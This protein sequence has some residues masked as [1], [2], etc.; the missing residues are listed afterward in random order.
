MSIR[1]F[2]IIAHIDHGKSTLA[3]RL[4]ERTGL[5]VGEKMREQMMD[6]MEL[7]RERGITIKAKTV[8]LTYE[9]KDGQTYILN[10]ID[11]PGHVD[12]TYEVSRALAAC[13][14]ALL[15]VDASQGVEAQTLA[16]F[17]L[18]KRQNLRI[19]SV[20]NKIDLPQSD[21][22]EIRRQIL[23]ILQIE[24][25]PLF[26]SAK[27][28]VGIEEILEAIV[29]KIPAPAGEAT[30]PLR[31]LVFD[32]LFSTFRGVIIT[33]RLFEGR[34]ARGM[35]VRF[36]SSP[37][38]EFEV[39]ELGYLILGMKPVRELAA[40]EVGYVILG[41]KDLSL[42]KMGDT[43]TESSRPATER[44]PGFQEL[45]PFVFCG[46][47][48]VASSDFTLLTNSLEKLHLEDSSFFFQPETSAALGFGF[49]CGFL[50]L[51]HMDIIKERIQREFNLP[52][53]ITA[54]NVV[55]KVK[56]KKSTSLYDNP[57]QFPPHGEIEKIEE[58][59]IQ[60]T[61]LT[62]SAYV[63]AV[64]QLCEA[65]R[66]KYISLRYITPQRAVL[67]YEMPLA[68]AILDFYDGLKSVSRG[69]GSLDY[70]PIGYR[71]G[72]LAKLE[73]LLA[74]E[75]VDA[76]SSIT[77]RER[78]YDQGR[79]LALKLKE[80]IPRQMFEVAIQARAQGKIISRETIPAKRKD[81]LAKCY[82]GDITRKRKLLEKQKEGKRRMKQIGS[83]EIPQEAFLAILK[84]E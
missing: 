14:G 70:E 34:L 52:L 13:E 64:M 68:E 74:G 28:G 25:E 1:N 38:K 61:V 73:I 45:K 4:L 66:A 15:L 53:L 51:L 79:K 22:P 8:R 80:L 58:P 18:A 65:R 26:A 60:A 77:A 35:K 57:A 63:G 56:T 67:I 44:L 72:D 2:S 11:T 48:P 29:Q 6:K 46:M 12:F 50:G 37:E 83:V 21:L 31:A 78:A 7:E 41:I 24:E 32:S 20:I 43:L 42:V 75:C 59:Y 17:H 84:I 16:N 3:D 76:L 81:V 36:L 23:E 39:E 30:R 71:E 5:V 69:Y 10:L 40:G 49:R 19:L 55:Y 33:L 47:Y 9:A 27:N 62:P 54:P 82:G